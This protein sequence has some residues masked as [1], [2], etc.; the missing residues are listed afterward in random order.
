MPGPVRPM[1]ARDRH[2]P[3]RAATQ[4]ELFYDLVSVIA[5]AAL[6]AEF[7]HAISD[8]HALEALPNFIF[9]FLAIWWAWMNYTWFASAFDNDDAVTR[10]LVLVIMAGAL[11]FAGGVPHLFET[12]ETGFGTIGW[13]IMR[14]GMVGLWLRAAAHN[15]GLASC[16]R[17]YALGISIAQVGWVL[18]WALL[19]PGSAAQIVF[20]LAVFCVEWNVPIWAE[21]KGPTPWHRHH[22]IERYGLM[23]II[24]LGE[25]LLSVALSFGALYDQFDAQLIIAALTGL[26]V[27]FMLFW[28]YFCEAEHLV[29]DSTVVAFIWG[30]GH[31][32]IF[33]AGALLGAG[34]G[35]WLDVA[36]HHSH[37]PDGVIGRHVGLPVALYLAA[38]WLVRDYKLHLGPRGMA[39]PVMALVIAGVSLT[40]T[41]PAVLVPL[42]LAA[43]LWR[44]PVGSAAPAATEAATEA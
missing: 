4:L 31:V 33:A 20:G 30:Y 26:L 28:L 42:L 12:L 35:A 22:I 32:L 10:A 18:L 27:V 1:T 13:I 16:C 34:V 8:G 29:S 6:T 24:V 7:H 17:R 44:I 25:V 15:P 3:H 38:L 11:I 37:L 2:E 5:I 39:L 9:T 23:N 14:V 19:P 36:A 41:T 43:L 40:G 21:K